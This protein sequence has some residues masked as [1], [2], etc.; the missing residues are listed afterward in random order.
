V[1]STF[2]LV[3]VCALALIAASTAIASPESAQAP[4][5]K[6]AP[7]KQLTQAQKKQP[8]VVG[9]NKG[10]TVRYFDFGPIKLK[11]GNK[12]APIWVFTNGAG[13]QRNV[14]DAVPGDKSYSPL[15]TV[16]QVTWADGETPRVLTSAGAI[17][18]AAAAGELKVVK[19]STVV[20]CPVLGFGQ[21]RIAGFS[22][23]RVIR[24]Y[25]LGPV[26]VR[27]GNAV[28]KLYTVTNGVAGQHNVTPDRIAPG[29][30]AYPPLWAIV[31]VT[32]KGGA[33][34]RLLTSNAAIQ[35][36]AAAGQVVLQPTSLVVN[37]PIV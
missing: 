2:R 11:P 28:V 8:V 10:K 22:A 34:P 18:K 9:F 32:W 29:Q 3:A 1:F 27:P 17:R 21:K 24:Y 20:N 36:A 15:W 19:T 37:C 23:G 4:G 13:G 35:R 14:I 12:V 5:S 31:K 16:N 25:D 7:T 26:K 30:T 6:K 33:K